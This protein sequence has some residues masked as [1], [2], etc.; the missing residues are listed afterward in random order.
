MELSSQHGKD[1]L[2]GPETQPRL[3]VGILGLRAEGLGV[4]GLTAEGLGILRLG[5]RDFGV[6]RLKTLRNRAGL[7][8]IFYQAYM[9]EP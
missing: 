3:N 4:L 1:V 5:F 7:R 9:K 6:W 8:G 2:G